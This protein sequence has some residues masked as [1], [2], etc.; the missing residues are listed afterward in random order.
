MMSALPRTKGWV[1]LPG[2]MVAAAK[3]DLSD[4]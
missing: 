2:A 3:A 4:E 1:V